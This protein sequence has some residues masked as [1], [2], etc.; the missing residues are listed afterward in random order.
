MSAMNSHRYV[1]HCRVL[2]E[3]NDAADRA[4]DAQVAHWTPMTPVNN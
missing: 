4:I 3:L 2:Q 1:E